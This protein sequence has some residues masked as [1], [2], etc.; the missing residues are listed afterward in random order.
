MSHDDAQP[1]TEDDAVGPDREP[2]VG[3]RLQ[4][5]RQAQSLSLTQIS[6]ALRIEPKFL[7]ALEEDRLEDLPAPVFAKGFLKQYG[8]VLGLDE[9]DLLAQYYRQADVRDVL[10]AHSMP[11]RLRDD[12]Q[13]R[14]W[15][16]G[17]V[18]LSFIVGGLA[19]WWINRPVVEPVVVEPAP[20]LAAPA[21]VPVIPPAPNE[22]ALESELP[23]SPAV[24]ELPSEPTIPAEMP[25]DAAVVQVGLG[26][27]EDSWTE[28]SDNQGERLFYGLGSAGASSSFEATLPISIFFGNAGGVELTVNGERY[29]IP[30]ESRQGNLARFVIAEPGF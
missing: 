19:A 20:D 30:A 4:V 17:A 21:Q 10:V 11:I 2:T 9:R 28:V 8:S 12:S 18:V 3:E 15:L 5:A 1:L 6:A 25:A 22:P 7:T 14:Y 16:A 24:T 27:S 26:F 13:I 29:P 23:G